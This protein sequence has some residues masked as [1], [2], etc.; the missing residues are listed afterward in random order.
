M[1]TLTPEQIAERLAR[2][3]AAN[4]HTQFSD[5]WFNNLTLNQLN[6]T[7]GEVYKESYRIAKIKRESIYIWIIQYIPLVELLECIQQLRKYDTVTLMGEQLRNPEL[8]A[9]DLKLKQ[10]LEEEKE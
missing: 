1:T 4:I 8:A 2:K 5:E 10:L 7:Y 3:C 9:L 6:S